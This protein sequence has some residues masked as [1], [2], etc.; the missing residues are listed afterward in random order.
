M[1]FL[2]ALAK[3]VLEEHR[4]NPL[5]RP[6]SQSCY[7]FPNRRSGLF[8][9]RFLV[10]HAK[11]TLWAPRI[12]TINE[13]MQELSGFEQADPLEALF[14]L[15]D[16][17]S[18]KS[19]SPEPFDSFYQWGEMM[20]NDFDTLDKYLADPVAIFRN[21]GELKEIDES[22]GTLEPEQVEFIRQF[23]KSFHQGETTQEKEIF[24]ATWKLLP[25]LYKELRSLLLARG[26]GYEGMIYRVVAEMEIA[27]L[28]KM[29][30]DN[31]YYFVGFNALSKSEKV[32]FSKLKKRGVASFFWDYDIEYIHDESMEA[33]RFLR[34]NLVMFPP[35]AD[36]GIFNNLKREREI[37]I[38]D[39][40]SD[41]LQAK[42]LHTLLSDRREKIT[43]A[44]DTT[45]VA[46]DENLLMPVLV[47]LPEQ[48]ELVNITMG[49][50]FSNTPLFSFIESILRLFRN[51]RKGTSG[52]GFYYKDVLSVLNHQYY[53]L[54][55]DEDPAIPVKGI[56]HE[57]HMYV[58]PSFFTEGF[59]AQVFRQVSSTDELCKYLGELVEYIL[60]RL[61]REEVHRYGELEK[62]Y[63][64]VVQGRLNKLEQAV[65]ERK[66]LE[67]ETFMRLFRRVMWNLRI[68]FTGEPLA[69]LQVMG[70]L[71]TRLLDFD[72][73]IMLSVN[74]DVMPGARSGNT[75]IP[76]SMRYAY[77]LPVREDMDAIYAYYFYRI[78]QRAK[79]VDLLFKSA[80][81]GV[82]SGEMSR[83]LYQMKYRYNAKVTG[84]V[85]P[86][87][88][89]EKNSIS[90][91]KTQQIIGILEKYQE[92]SEDSYYLSPSAL[93]T[94]LDCSLKFYFRKIAGIREQEE[95]LEELD[96][97][98]IGNILHKTI[99]QLYKSL[100]DG[101]ERLTEAYLINLTN[102]DLIQ[103]T[104]EEVFAREF[105]RTSGKRKIEGRNLLILAIIKRYLLKI[106]E[107]D[108]KIAPLEL[109]AMEEVF[110]M[111]RLIATPT[112][113]VMVRLGGMIDR[114]DRPAGGVDRV[115]DYKTGKAGMTL[116]SI[117][118]LFDR[119]NKNRNKAAFQAFLYAT[120]FHHRNPDV[121]VQPG[122]YVV[123]EMFKEGYNPLFRMGENRQKQ[124]IDSF[125][126]Y[127]EEFQ[128]YLDWVLTEIF[129]PKV[130]FV[131]TTVTEHCKNCDFKSICERD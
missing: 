123:R 124:Q 55:S 25:V 88:A 118:S 100:P 1:M 29:L 37:R 14:T 121:P 33:G 8:F 102:S 39:L 58:D 104:L 43:E 95:L 87:S 59:A 64:L 41:I 103:A 13:L 107:T 28:N 127:M 117:A 7:I 97:T 16:I 85:L 52:T 22:F 131:Q 111:S 10:K 129:D 94:Y 116:T 126:E 99:H 31:H 79:K 47:S 67:P 35:E 11:G 113:S 96:P 68:P 92:G 128:E 61:L 24:L 63:I 78:I 17:Y 93:N 69:G 130:P 122:L 56:I 120:L 110:T 83:Y 4:S 114:V 57:N 54:I 32:L 50:P 18:A 109:V 105:F 62:E 53:K 90:I 106:I 66:G 89:A 5:R 20:L 74:E 6:L 75:F 34:E 49:Y 38:F 77:G 46:C 45:I 3:Y 12:F 27:E 82:R 42:S 108:I 26:E 48:V 40:P 51:M 30:S 65:G 119:E 86:V 101:S 115:I 76:W 125:N 98:G 23:W 72:H 36:L 70:I 91:N 81:E 112:G 9:K 15:H 60:E 84:P 73:V 44:N 71:E 21:I 2:E 19:P 80:S